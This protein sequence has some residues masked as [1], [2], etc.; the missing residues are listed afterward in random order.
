MQT[1]IQ[2]YNTAKQA[3][4]HT[5]KERYLVLALLHG[6]GEPFGQTSVFLN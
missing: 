2:V 3:I 5:G 6:M 1:S 4:I